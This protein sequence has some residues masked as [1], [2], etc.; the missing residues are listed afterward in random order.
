M[1]NFQGICAA[2]R[3]MAAAGLSLL[4]AFGASAQTVRYIHTDG[5][6]SPVLVTDKDRNVVERSEY[7]PYGSILNRPLSDDV[8]YAGHIGDAITGLT[9]M[10]QRYY[11]PAVGR[12][13]SSDPIGSQNGANFNRY[14]YGGNNPYRYIDPDGRLG[15]DKD[16]NSE[17]TIPVANMDTITVTP[18][19]DSSW[20]WITDRNW[21]T[22]DGSLTDF[23]AIWHDIYYPLMDTPEGAPFKLAGL[24]G[25]G[26]FWFEGASN[27]SREL[28]VADLGVKGTVTELRGA[29]TV[30]D[31]VATMRVD[32]LEGRILNPYRIVDNMVETARATGATSLRIEASFANEKLFDFLARRYNV[33]SEGANETITI[34]LK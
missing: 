21:F 27:F 10:Q 11:D 5:L 16:G 18:T 6:G 9:Y 17:P 7:E 34:S 22:G 23:G 30:K 8:A 31:G 15:K 28:R 12:F 25:K 13:L 14:W 4:I 1:S 26:F 2:L 29:F 20:S 24:A 19:T 33:V 32:M 3:L